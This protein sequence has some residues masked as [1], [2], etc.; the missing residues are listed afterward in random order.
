M[1]A[2]RR[3]ALTFE[4]GAMLTWVVLLGI[5]SALYPSVSNVATLH[6]LFFGSG[7]LVR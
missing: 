1:D 5:G 3:R 6:Q 2:D 4:V 7:A